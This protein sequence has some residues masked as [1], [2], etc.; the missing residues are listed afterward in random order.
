[1][2][3]IMEIR[4]IQT[5]RFIKD[6]TRLIDQHRLSTEDFKE[7]KEE[8]AEHPKTGDVIPG[9]GGVRKIRLKTAGQGKSGGF[10]VCYF[11]HQENVGLYLLLIYPKNEQENLTNEQTK[12]LRELAREIKKNSKK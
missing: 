11:Y 5:K 12:F 8:L 6:V 7:F 9:A 4:I 1:M 2:I 3:N 10:R